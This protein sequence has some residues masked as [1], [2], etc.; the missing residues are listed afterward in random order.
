MSDKDA[1]LP[2]SF[3]QQGEFHT[4]KIKPPVRDQIEALVDIENHWWKNLQAIDK[5]LR[6][7]EK[8]EW[9]QEAIAEIDDALAFRLARKRMAKSRYMK[10][11]GIGLEGWGVDDGKE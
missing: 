1:P 11:R 9:V 8:Q 10:E 4:F 2:K 6:I 3:G 7:H 5:L